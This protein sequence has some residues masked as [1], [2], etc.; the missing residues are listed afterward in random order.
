V[1]AQAI[2]AL[3]DRP[4]LT[5]GWHLVVLIV[6]GMIVVGILHRIIRRQLAL[7]QRRSRRMNCENR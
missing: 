5:E 6:V 3:I 7:A 1:G 2:S 4:P